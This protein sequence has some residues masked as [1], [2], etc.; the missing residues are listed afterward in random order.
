MVAF[1]HGIM[2]QRKKTKVQGWDG[3]HFNVTTGPL[4]PDYECPFHAP[5]VHQDWRAAVWP[6]LHS[7]CLGTAGYKGYV[8]SQPPPEPTMPLRMK[9]R[10]G[11]D[12]N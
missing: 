8:L 4:D 2:E 10:H 5:I 12:F 1:L 6:Y 11:C 3:S 9:D 7:T